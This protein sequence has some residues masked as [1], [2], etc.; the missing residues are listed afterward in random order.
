MGIYFGDFTVS[1]FVED[2]TFTKGIDEPLDPIGPM[3]K[4]VP[5]LD[6]NAREV[7][8]DLGKLN[9][10]V[11]RIPLKKIQYN[12]AKLKEF[13]EDVL[14]DAKEQ[15]VSFSSCIMTL[16]HYNI[17]NEWK[18]MKLEEL[19]RRLVRKQRVQ[20]TVRRNT[21]QG[22]INM[23]ILNRR[24]REKRDKFNRFSR[25][26]ETVVPNIPEIFVNDGEDSEPSTPRA[27]SPEVGP[28]TPM[29]SPPSTS[30]PGSR[31]RNALPRLDT[32]VASVGSP[33]E[34]HSSSLFARLSN[35]SPSLS[36]RFRST[37]DAEEDVVTPSE[38]TLSQHE[39]RD[40]IAS[41]GASAWGE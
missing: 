23:W 33:S 10:R 8:I 30:E 7:W 19:L 28:Q 11:N 26:T 21:V 13:C 12:R 29:L 39:M 41:L 20:E 15:G 31:N 40:V 18:S 24:Y 27:E 34:G 16:V 5:K 17:I 22:F 37:R 32:S 36:P 14:V 2:C 38:G 9:R 4:S 25:M 35:L 6:G 3:I 1:R